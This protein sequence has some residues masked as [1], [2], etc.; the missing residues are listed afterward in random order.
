MAASIRSKAAA[1]A[2]LGSVLTVAPGCV[3]YLH[4]VDRPRPQEMETCMSI[5]RCSRDH[6]YV[7][8]VHGMDPFN[9]AN[10]SGLRD[11]VQALGFPKTYYGQLYHKWTFESDIRKVR[12]E[13]PEARIVL[14]GYSF[15]ANVVRDLAKSAQKD[16]IDIDLLFYIGGNTLRNTPEDQPDNAV[17][18]VHILSSGWDWMGEPIDRA[19]NINIPE[20]YHFG[21]PT[22]PK[23]LR[24][25][26]RRLA[27]VASAM[28]MVE[29]P[30]KPLSTL[31][32]D[33]PTPTT[34]GHVAQ[35]PVERETIG[36]EWNF[37]EPISRLHMPRQLPE[38]PT[39]E[40]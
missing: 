31:H 18:I 40:P 37:L 28:P 3:S 29:T 32:Q 25:L 34:M 20:V 16:G 15:G 27:E 14:V 24:A 2:L 39:R 36:T 30:E 22:N 13:D 35:K 21:T 33:E 4:P 6:I 23:T 1:A 12:Q 7:F 10:L 9:Y 8:I 11:Y 5:P 38:P 26:A 17:R 19:E